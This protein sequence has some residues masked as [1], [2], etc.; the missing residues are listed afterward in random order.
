MFPA[1]PWNLDLIFHSEASCAEE[2]MCSVHHKTKILRFAQDD[3]SF[4]I[5]SFRSNHF[6]FG[7]FSS[8]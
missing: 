8:K 7:S 5:K 4:R 3:I 6:P 1:F 2:S